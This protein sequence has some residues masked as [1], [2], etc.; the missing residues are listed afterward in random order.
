MV[1]PAQTAPRVTAND[2]RALVITMAIPML[3]TRGTTDLLNQAVTWDRELTTL[4]RDSRLAARLAQ[5]LLEI[6]RILDERLTAQYMERFQSH[7]AR[8]AFY[9]PAHES[10]NEWLIEDI[11]PFGKVDVWRTYI[12]VPQPRRRRRRRRPPRQDMTPPPPSAGRR[13]PGPSG[14]GGTGIGSDIGVIA[15]PSDEMVP[16]PVSELFPSGAM[17]IIEQILAT[18]TEALGSILG[19]IIS[20]FFTGLSI[21]DSFE[22]TRRTQAAAAKRFAI[23]LALMALDGLQVT[24]PTV[25][26]RILV[27]EIRRNG[28]LNSAWLGQTGVQLNSTDFDAILEEGCRVVAIGYS[29]AIRRSERDF[30]RACEQ[31]G[32]AAPTY[33]QI[34]ELRNLVRNELV[35]TASAQME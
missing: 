22:G 32:V 21:V 35:K 25:S 10:P 16:G 5:A 18:T 20:G 3:R 34:I 33:D 19:P 14:V 17:T 31:A 29:T 9:I 6:H 26:A 7:Q 28:I 11:Y 4:P 1:D 15:R 23:R 30:I 12:T 27:N 8:E 2:A 24:R 13:Q